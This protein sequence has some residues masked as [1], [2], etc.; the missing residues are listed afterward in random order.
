MREGFPRNE[1]RDWGTRQEIEKGGKGMKEQRWLIM[2]DVKSE[3]KGRKWDMRTATDGKGLSIIYQWNGSETTVPMDPLQH[4]S[5]WKWKTDEREEEHQS[6]ACP[7]IQNSHQFFGQTK[8]DNH[9]KHRISYDVEMV[10]KNNNFGPRKEMSFT[11]WSQ[12][13]SCGQQQPLYDCGR[14]LNSARTRKD[15]SRSEGFHISSLN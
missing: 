4:I 3:M 15:G 14:C 5:C 6:K 1:A 7:V 10:I 9:V 12:E 11:R 8:Y 13:K 2:S